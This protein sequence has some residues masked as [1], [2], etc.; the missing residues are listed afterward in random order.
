MSL[1]GVSL[2][3]TPAITTTSQKEKKSEYAMR[4]SKEGSIIRFVDH[5]TEVRGRM[6]RSNVINPNAVSL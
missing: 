4:L 6:C 2:G 1:S 5:I 3:S